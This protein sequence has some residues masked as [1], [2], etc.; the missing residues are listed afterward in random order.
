VDAA[1]ARIAGGYFPFYRELGLSESAIARFEEI[2]IS[3][4]G[5]RYENFAGIGA[6][7]LEAAP[8]LS[9]TE[10]NERLRQLLGES[11][12]HRLEEYQKAQDSNYANRLA[13]TLYFTDTPLTTEQGTQLGRMV[14]EVRSREPWGTT[15][16]QVFWAQI[17]DRTSAFLASS[18]R[19]ALEGLQ[20]S[21]DVLWASRHRN[22]Q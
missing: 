6:M 10:K 17:R 9:D 20:A 14:A 1:K 5:N 22:G 7:T 8:T 16:P 3:G 2:M 18:Q 13:S 19:A 21:D 4:A 11:G 12:F 15:P